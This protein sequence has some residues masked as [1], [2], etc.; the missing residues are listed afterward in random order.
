MLA[1]PIVAELRHRGEDDNE[2]RR[3][4][5]CRLLA[6]VNTWRSCMAMV[7]VGVTGCRCDREG[8]ATPDSAP[9]GSTS[10]RRLVMATKSGD[11]GLSGVSGPV[12]LIVAHVVADVITNANC[13]QCGSGVVLYV[14]VSCKKVVWPKRGRATS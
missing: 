14:C 5:G 11:K 9:C 6:C 2:Q 7:G 12:L 3:G 13:P 10:N 1:L 8:V 4:S